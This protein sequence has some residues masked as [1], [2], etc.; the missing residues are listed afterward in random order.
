MKKI[1]LFVILTWPRSRL[2]SSFGRNN[3]SNINALKRSVDKHIP[4][5]A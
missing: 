2:R 4:Y 5:I 1:N 3:P